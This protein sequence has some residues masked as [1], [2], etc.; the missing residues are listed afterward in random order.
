MTGRAWAEGEL[1]DLDRIYATRTEA[2][3]LGHFPGKSIGQIRGQSIKR[4]LSRPAN[5]QAFAIRPRH[6]AALF[7]GTVFPRTVRKAEEA[8]R[9]LVPGRDQRKLGGRVERPGAWHGFPIFSLTLE[10]R[11]TCPRSC[12][13]WLTC[14]G[15][16][17]QWAARIDPLDPG[18]LSALDAELATL[19]RRH[20]GGFVVRLHI[21]GDFFSQVYVRAWESW[22]SRYPALRVFGYTARGPDD[23]IGAM[24]LDLAAR[25]WDRFAVRLSAET[26]APGRAITTDNPHP[27]KREGVFTCPAETIHPDGTKKTKGC[28]TCGLCWRAPDKAVQFILHGGAKRGRKP[29]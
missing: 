26:P 11:A 25:R 18:F 2:E 29:Q 14:Y 1:A 8:H 23:P 22:L 6:P 28:N 27:P 24:V 3:L 21:L 19:Q 13:H 16:A 4:Q 12:H 10:E 5:G 9:L 15:N 7:G 20:R 17:M